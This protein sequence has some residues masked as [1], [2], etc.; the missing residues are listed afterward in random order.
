VSKADDKNQDKMFGKIIPDPNK[1]SFKWNKKRKM[2]TSWQAGP[3]NVWFVNHD[4]DFSFLSGKR[5]FLLGK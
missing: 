3:Y 5:G 4:E 1:V 2:N